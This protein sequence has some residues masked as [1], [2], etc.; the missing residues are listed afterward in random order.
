MIRADFYRSRENKLLGFHISGHAGLAEEGYDV[1]CAAV[2]SAVMM[3]CNTVTDVFK[4]DAKVD[5]DENDILLKLG[6]DS[7]GNGDRLLLG[8]MLQ[9]DMISQEYPSAVK[10]SVNDR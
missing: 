2:S 10:I 7:E 8:L 5:V 3:T 4:I 1:A 6:N 9:L